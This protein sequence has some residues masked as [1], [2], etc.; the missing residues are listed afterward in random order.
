VTTLPVLDPDRT[1]VAGAG[2]QAIAIGT[3]L[4]TQPHPAR[5]FLR[6]LKAYDV[7]NGIE[8]LLTPQALYN[9]QELFL[10]E[11]DDPP[12][13]QITGMFAGSIIHNQILTID[14]QIDTWQS[15]SDGLAEFLARDGL[16]DY[17][18]TGLDFIKAIINVLDG[19][20]RRQRPVRWL[21]LDAYN[22]V[23]GEQNTA[24][25]E[26]YLFST[27]A[28]WGRDGLVQA[29]DAPVG[30]T[31]A[32]YL[33]D[34]RARLDSGLGSGLG[35]DFLARKPLLY[36]LI[37][38]TLSLMPTDP[39]ARARVGDALD[40]LA[41]RTPDELE[42]LLRESLGLGTHRLDAWATAL[43][44][45]RLNQMRAT[46]PDGIQIGGFGWV[47]DLS[48]GPVRPSQGFV[49]APSMAHATTAALLRSGWHAHGT[50][51]PLSLVAV[52]ASSAR[53][54]TAS[55]L[56]DGVRQGQPLGT[57]LG[58]RFE[59]SLHDLGADDQIRSVR[60]QVLVAAGSPDVPPDQPVDGIELLDLHRAGGLTGLSR[61]ALDAVEL[62][63]AAFDAVNDIGLVEAVHQ[64]ASGNNERATALLDALSTGV[65]APPELRAPLTPRAGLAVEHRV[66]ILLDPAAPPAPWRG[67]T[68]GV[69]DAVAPALDGWVASLLP[70][71][72]EVGFVARR[73]A[74][75][76]VP[77]VTHTL[78]GLGL[79]ALDA[80][81][82]VGDHPGGVSP[83]LRALAAASGGPVEID[84]ADAGG[85]RVSLADFTVLAVELRRAIVKLRP[86]DAR[87]LRPGHTAGTPDVDADAALDA[88]EARVA[89]FADLVT[90]L[91]DA[92]ATDSGAVAQ[93]AERLARYSLATGE[94]AADPV[95]AAALAELAGRRLANVTAVA[96][97]PADRRPG[98]ERRL[99]AMLGE[100][101]PVLGTFSLDATTIDVASTVAPSAEVDGWLD[102]VGRVRSDVGRLTG[103]GLLS[104]L[105]TTDGGL[106]GFAGQAPFT[107]GEPWVAVGRAGARL[108]IVALSRPGGLPRAGSQACGLVVDRWTER[109]PLA[110]QVTG[111]ALHF[112]APSNSP[113]QAW[114]LAVPPVDEAWSL[115]LV[116]DT[117]LET[118]E[119]ATLRAVSPEDLGD[120]GR[121]IPT[122][123]VPGDV[124]NWPEEP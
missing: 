78:A 82:L 38:Q 122:V 95:A 42:W 55:W 22:G 84:P 89:D 99:A 41:G 109:V 15:V 102:T 92:V 4:A 1:D 67:W 13:E 60:Q 45:E 25:V 9:L 98:L 87:D 120:Y 53:V 108:S 104:E 10:I 44:A 3:V 18:Q 26:G 90:R 105:L 27:S 96:V 88:V 17:L 112:D 101:V 76:E 8:R 19:Y 106:R 121:A 114:L 94:P 115:Q 47:H 48:P 69:R 81:Y 46:R 86:A 91:T 113:P 124:V 31:A 51:D 103:A 107:A 2:D 66:I 65:L 68:A 75:S 50:D 117:L 56:L 93:V 40:E 37:D 32:D 72:D 39:I 35:P 119:W 63:E 77:T 57:L 7:L 71:A 59:R 118:L 23:L 123:F 49:H 79:S 73:A 43:A 30:Q 52:D 36:Q 24:L 85:A 33:A 97:D 62:V 100:R 64:L 54:R 14:Q 34:L 74:G 80:I 28:E 20:E 5:L 21:P 111:V 70:R 110:E 61:D 83:A 29:P 16:S 6:T 12:Y 58:Y 116:L 11:H